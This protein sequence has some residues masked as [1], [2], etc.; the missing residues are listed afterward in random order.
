[1]SPHLDSRS[2]QLSHKKVISMRSDFVR[3]VQ[4][5]EEIPLW[6]NEWQQAEAQINLRLKWDQPWTTRLNLRSRFNLQRARYQRKTTL[7]WDTK[8]QLKTCKFS[9]FT[10][11]C[12]RSIVN[13]P[14]NLGFWTASGCFYCRHRLAMVTERVCTDL[15]RLWSLT[16]ISVGWYF[17]TILTDHRYTQVFFSQQWLLCKC[18]FHWRQY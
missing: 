1:M 8:E 12:C 16:D 7:I 3:K 18:T 17:Q 13:F 9:S 10:P 2:A 5:S 6:L 11:I 14:F 15:P 4:E